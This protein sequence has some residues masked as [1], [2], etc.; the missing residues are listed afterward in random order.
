MTLEEAIDIIYDKYE[1]CEFYFAENDR[2]PEWCEYDFLEAL[3]VAISAL[4]EIQQYREI[5]TVEKCRGAV[6]KLKRTEEALNVILSW[7]Y[8]DE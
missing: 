7:N 3:G 8:N 6:E 2:Y 1:T 4:E 5:G